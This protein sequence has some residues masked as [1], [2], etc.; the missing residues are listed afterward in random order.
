MEPIVIMATRLQRLSGVR[1]LLMALQVFG[2]AAGHTDRRLH[3]VGHGLAVGESVERE[4]SLPG[5]NAG[6]TAR[7][8][9]VKKSRLAMGLQYIRVISAEPGNN[10]NLFGNAESP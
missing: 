10:I 5:V 8:A 4:L 6:R 9:I 2:M 7:H 3:G 1:N